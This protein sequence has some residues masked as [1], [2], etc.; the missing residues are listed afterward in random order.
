MVLFC[1]ICWL[2][3]SPCRRNW[4]DPPH[5][6]GHPSRCTR[7]TK[8][9]NRKETFP[10][11][12]VVCTKYRP[13]Q[14]I[15]LSPSEVHQWRKPFERNLRAASYVN[16]GNCNGMVAM[17]TS[18]GKVLLWSA[19]NS[20]LLVYWG[21]T[22]TACCNRAH[23]SNRNRTEAKWKLAISAI[24][25]RYRRQLWLQKGRLSISRYA[26]LN[27]ENETDQL[28]FS[29]LAQPQLS[30]L[31][32]DS[33]GFDGMHLSF[34]KWKVIWKYTILGQSLEKDSKTSECLCRPIKRDEATRRLYCSSYVECNCF[35]S[36]LLNQLYFWVV[37]AIV[38]WSKM[39]RHNCN[40]RDVLEVDFWEFQ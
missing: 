23:L 39:G 21:S 4:T 17:I 6:S 28:L 14:S 12:P 24:I 10:R 37:D 38:P 27:S 33:R 32:A 19:R 5:W 22:G 1:G 15:C 34:G 25:D 40:K 2:L 31:K 18:S 7:M 13:F 30:S 35:M 11:Y 8:R 20:H 9:C 16:T 36:S 26:S 3:A 29:L